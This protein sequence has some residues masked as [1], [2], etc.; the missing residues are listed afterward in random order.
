MG[1]AERSP[2]YRVVHAHMTLLTD[3]TFPVVTPYFTG[4]MA[5]HGSLARRS[6]WRLLPTVVGMVAATSVLAA[7]ESSASGASFGVRAIGSAAIHGGAARVEH[8]AEAIEFG[9]RMD[10]GHFA[11]RRIRVIGDVA[12]L[13]SR[14]HAEYV[15]FEDSTFRNVFYDL[16][17]H[18][19]IQWFALDPAGPVAPYILTGV[20]VHSLTSNFGSIVL[21]QRYNTNNFGLLGAV[22]TRVKFAKRSSIFV[23]VSRSLVRNVRRSSLRIGL[24]ALYG[25]LMRH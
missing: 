3:V 25:D 24:E 14:E 4:P 15:V 16:S 10:V 21:D 19:A 5:S 23:E 2:A 9:A 7:Q 12:F 6:A 8:G 18:V 20:G 13:R 1:H 22:G 11:I 17:G